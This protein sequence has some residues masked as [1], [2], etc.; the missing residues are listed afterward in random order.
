M[1]AH[2]KTQYARRKKT[3]II[4]R[5]RNG[6]SCRAIAESLEIPEHQ[7]WN[8]MRANG[9]AGKYRARPASRLQAFRDEKQSLDSMLR[10]ILD[11]ADYMEI[12]RSA[13]GTGWIVTIDDLSGDQRNTV[14]SATAG[15][16]MRWK[17]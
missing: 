4:D 13:D 6:E 7:I 15:A 16:F 14:D 11:T 12:E 5:R 17:G 2:A 8:L 1:S 3:E 10:T 9:E